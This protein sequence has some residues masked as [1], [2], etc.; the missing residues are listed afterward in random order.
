LNKF[1]PKVLSHIPGK[2]VS[3]N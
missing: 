3:L 2:E 1:L